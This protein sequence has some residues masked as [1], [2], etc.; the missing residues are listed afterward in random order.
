MGVI[1]RLPDDVVNR[2]AAGEVVVRPAN[3]IIIGCLENP[4][5]VINS[6]LLLLPSLLIKFAPI[7]GNTLVTCNLIRI[8]YVILALFYFLHCKSYYYKLRRVFKHH[9]EETA[10][11]AD[12][13]TRYAVNR[14]D[15]SFAMRRGGS[16]TDFR[17]SGH[18]DRNVTVAALLGKECAE[19]EGI[20]ILL[21]FLYIQM[22]LF[23]VS[24]W[25]QFLTEVYVFHSNVSD[26]VN[27]SS[28]CSELIDHIENMQCLM[29]INPN[30][31]LGHYFMIF[32]DKEIAP[33]SINEICSGSQQLL[34]D[35]Q[36]ERTPSQAQ[37][38]SNF[39]SLFDKYNNFLN[40]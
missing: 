36:I 27:D 16:G 21:Y 5:L 19:V 24:S 18:G 30:F 32:Y 9:A 31:I 25:E 15:V 1:Q 7:K 29:R 23:T 4:E 28:L 40:L 20:P 10:R 38:S 17:T 12:V 26:T 33:R 13:V 14:P 35:S 37:V 6:R 22:T 11:I 2:I 8:I 3:A 34:T 39:V